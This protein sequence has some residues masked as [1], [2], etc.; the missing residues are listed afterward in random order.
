[1]HWKHCDRV[2]VAVA[3]VLQGSRS[4]PRRVFPNP[5]KLGRG[6]SSLVSRVLWGQNMAAPAVG[7]NRP[8]LA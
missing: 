4:G 1:M 3:I 8:A 6:R 5:F 7:E 2:G